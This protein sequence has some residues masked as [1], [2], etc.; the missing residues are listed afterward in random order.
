MLTSYSNGQRAGLLIGW[1]PMRM[2]SDL[3]SWQPAGSQTVWQPYAPPA[4]LETL[5]DGAK[6]TVDMPGVDP[7]DVEITFAAGQL[8][9]SG[10]R[11]DQTYRY[12]VDLG[13]SIDPEH[14][15]AD[16]DKGVLTVF[17]HRKPEAKPRKIALQAAS[18]TKSLGSGDGDK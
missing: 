15:E 3:M 2:F 1:D 5:E 4:T 11:G 9:V 7:K 16:L 12:T 14:I 8:S 6:I 13:D 18:R 10:K 17:A